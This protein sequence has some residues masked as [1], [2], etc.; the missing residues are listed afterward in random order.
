M[1]RVLITGGAGFVG[2]NLARDLTADG[3]E[4]RILDDLSAARDRYVEGLGADLRHGSVTDPASV[5]RAVKGVDAVVHLAAMSGRREAPAV[6][7]HGPQ[8]PF[9]LRGVEALR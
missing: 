1:T 4:V 6:R 5:R 2:S 9:P 3:V 8:R 7:G